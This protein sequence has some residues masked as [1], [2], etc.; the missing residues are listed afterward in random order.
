MR[1]R[2]VV[3]MRQVTNYVLEFLMHSSRSRTPGTRIGDAH[4]ASAIVSRSSVQDSRRTREDFPVKDALAIRS[5]AA[6]IINKTG[7]Y[8]PSQWAVGRLGGGFILAYHDLPAEIF[9]QQ[10]EALR[11]NQPVHLSELFQRA[12]TGRSTAGLFAVT[13]DDGVATTVQNISAVCKRRQ[14]P[15]T[16]YLPT[17][18]LD[19]RRGLPF[20]L[21]NKVVPYLP[22]GVLTLPSRVLDLS[23]T[24]ALERFKADVETAIYTQHYD[25]YQS[26][27]EDLVRWVLEHDLATTEHLQPP[28]PIL[29]S[30]VVDL[31]RHEA[32]RFESHGVTHTAV[33]ALPPATLE[34]ELVTSKRRI[35]EHT[36]RECRHFCYPFGG[37][38]S[39]GPVAPEIVTK[40]Y[41]TATTMSRGR[42]R[43]HPWSLVPRIPI[44]E[45]DDPSLVRLKILT[46]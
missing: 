22:K 14:W 43:H 45:R 25:D 21:W 4:R 42:L 36:N 19:E 15:V 20:Q 11:P 41:D 6:W 8:Y 34:A 28:E 44:Y 32:I 2:W 37:N 1:V 26:L 16:F 33:V 31:S 29:W 24:E 46:V 35:S 30:E 18:Y 9:E 40:V 5:V 27:I 39:I 3:G 23:T 13:F 10:M 12:A 38:E 17:V 7:C